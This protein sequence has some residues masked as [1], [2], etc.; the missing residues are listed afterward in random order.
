M[1]VQDRIQ[2]LRE[3]IRRHDLLYYVEAQPEITDHE[4][5][6][7]FRE[8][9][10]LEARY[11]AL[12]SADS[13]T[14]RVGGV[15][16][17]AFATVDH[18]RPM[19]S[20][21]NTYS[22]Q[23]VADFHRRV[24][25][26][27]GGEAVDYVCELKYDGVALSL[28]YE[29]GRLIRAVTR[30][31]GER[32]DVITS[33][34]RTIRA[35][36][37]LLPDASWHVEVRGEV[38]M[39]ND[40]FLKLNEALLEVG[41][42][43]FAN[44]RNLTAGSL[45]QKNPAVTAQRPLQFVAYSLDIDRGPSEP[46]DHWESLQLLRSMGFPVSVDVGLCRDP[47]CV[48]SF[49]DKWDAS[50]DSIPFGIDGVVVKV[51]N[52]RQRSILGMVAR[53]PRWAIAYKY[54]A[55]KVH[56]KLLDITLQVGRTGAVTPV[57][58]L[59]PVLLAGSTISRATLH[60]AYFVHTLDLRVGDT[61]VVEKGG[62]VIPKV[63][64]IV[65]SLRPANAHPWVMP[66]SCPCIRKSPLINVEGEAATHCIDSDCPWQLRRRLQHFA[67]RGAMDIEGLGERAI[68]QLVT[69]GLLNGIADIYR[70]RDRRDDIVT[71]DRW[72]PRSVDNLL[73]SVEGSKCQ[74]F[75]RVL[76]ALG[77]RYVGETVARNLVQ[78][79]PTVDALANATT[80]DLTAVHDIGDSIAQSVSQWFSEPPNRALIEQLRSFGLCLDHMAAPARSR[81]GITGRSFVFTGTLLNRQRREAE[82]LVTA[83]GGKAL[84]SV[85]KKTDYVVAG[86]DAG[87]KLV[88]AIELGVTILSE[89]D[90]ERLLPE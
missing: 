22:S 27:V 46:A 65:P 26:G 12:V 8:L 45:K 72:A 15:A 81:D 25:Q 67:S 76:Y 3:A 4:Y 35:I 84:S 36:P 9:Q 83:L 40:D 44:P 78:A 21:S 5:D 20:L 73:D 68:D 82:E 62:D 49:L 41:E 29:G 30:G 53:A 14:Q 86:A 47:E 56:T 17:G 79:F 7:L 11:P 28:V 50:R 43:T 63:A 64:G 74:S 60:N 55:R 19:L 61:V 23:E 34:V 66:S 2:Y 37:L 75:Q 85:S 33:N 16:T 80:H 52:F 89:E 54:A 48:R 42:K 13:P 24:S 1:S 87:S 59:T 6:M 71:L 31:D 69:A 51:N 38:Y 70:L 77:I 90:F 39:R 10:D 57:A 58:E 32:G 88:K 18:A